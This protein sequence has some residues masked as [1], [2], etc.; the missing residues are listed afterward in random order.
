M[1]STLEGVGGQCHNLATS[2]PGNK[3][4]TRFTGG[5]LGLRVGLGSS[6]KF[7]PHQHLN[8]NPPSP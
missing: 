6:K 3:P 7:G 4:N 1:T 2:F 5:W 8:T